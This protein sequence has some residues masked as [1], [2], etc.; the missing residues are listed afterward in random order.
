MQEVLDCQQAEVQDN[1]KENN[2]GLRVE[3]SRVCTT[4]ILRKPSAF[5]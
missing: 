4:T 3:E 5:L 2:V 1:Q